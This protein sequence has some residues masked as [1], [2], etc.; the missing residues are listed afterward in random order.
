[1]WVARVGSGLT[2]AERERLAGRFAG[3]A[4]DDRPFEPDPEFPRGARWVEPE[5]V[6]AVEYTEV[7]E[8]R[9]L[10]APTYQGRRDDADPKECLI[11]DIR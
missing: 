2:A 10:R 5:I 8:A 11:T 9:R 3:L 4:R 6:C 1:L 7:T